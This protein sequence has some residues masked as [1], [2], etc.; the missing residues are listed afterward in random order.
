M[1]EVKGPLCHEEAMKSGKCEQCKAP[2]KEDL[3]STETSN[4]RIQQNYF[5]ER[6]PLRARLFW[7]AN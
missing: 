4:T 5:I 7:R 2:M 1:I 3:D 6:T